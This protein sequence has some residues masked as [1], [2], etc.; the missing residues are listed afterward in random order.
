[1]PRYIAYGLAEGT[2]FI[3]E[4]EAKDRAEAAKMAQNEPEDEEGLCE[5]CSV[6]LGKRRG[7]I[8]EEM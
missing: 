3:G 8:V 5:C 4:Y 2:Y 6:E 1:M 7:L